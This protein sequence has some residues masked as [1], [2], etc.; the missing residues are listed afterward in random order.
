MSTGAGWWLA[1]EMIEKN[2]IKDNAFVTRQALLDLSA[3]L[4]INF[5]NQYF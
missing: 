4:T 5:S 3:I 2:N 1:Y